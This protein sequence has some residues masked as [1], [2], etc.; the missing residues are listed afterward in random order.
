[1]KKILWPLSAMILIIASCA[2]TAPKTLESTPEEKNETPVKE[3]VIETAIID[4]Y[5]VASESLSASDGVV[6]GYIEYEYD[7]MGNLLVKKELDSEKKMLSRLVNT[8][9]GEDLIK[10]QWFRGEDNEPGIYIAR[11]FEGGKLLTETSYDIKEVPQSI[12]IYEYDSNNNVVK[13]IVSSGDNVP[14]MVTEYEYNGDN[15]TKAT[16]LSPLG[17][18]EGYIEYNWIGSNLESEKTSDKNGDLEKSVLYE[19]LDGNLV[20][21][22]HYKK[23]VVSYIIEYEHD[24]KGNVIR[25]KH[26]YRSGNLKAQ[27]DY[28]YISVKKEVRL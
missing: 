27:W 24:E 5:L 16:F 18:M 7:Q 10:T 15:R 25:K 22:I 14:M 11:D 4:V 13:W 9:S 6:D 28:S 26:F 12:S 17:E 2:T 1:M 21:E 20:K 8:V 19:Y 23:T 3:E